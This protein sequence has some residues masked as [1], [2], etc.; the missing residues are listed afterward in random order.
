MKDEILSR[1][2]EAAEYIVRTGAAPGLRPKILRQQIH[3]S[4]GH[5]PASAGNRPESGPAGGPGAGRQPEPA[6]SAGRRRHPGQIRGSAQEAARAFR[7]DRKSPEILPDFRAKTG[8]P[9]A[10]RTRGLSLR[11][12]TL[13]PAELRRQMQK[14]SQQFLYY[15]TAAARCQGGSFYF[16]G[17]VR[18][19]CPASSIGFFQNHPL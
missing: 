1:A 3:H 6:P 12:R 17:F 15:G 13:Y 11:R 16:S 8:V 9:G 19:I 4:Q 7:V 18:P 2:V 10:I 14:Y 5:A